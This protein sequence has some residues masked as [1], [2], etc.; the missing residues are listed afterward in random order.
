M[1]T[2][3]AFPGIDIKAINDNFVHFMRSSLDA[4]YKAASMTQDIGIQIFKNVLESG[5]QIQTEMT[6][7]V[8]VMVENTK[9]GTEE[10]KRVCEE[11]LKTVENIYS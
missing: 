8:D 11:G 1:E 5:K 2:K 7:I 6:K 3:T 9:K 4:T 10:Y